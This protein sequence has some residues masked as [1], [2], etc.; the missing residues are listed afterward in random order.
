MTVPK[1]A[2]TPPRTLLV[3]GAAGLLGGRLL[4]LAR[5]GLRMVPACV[6]EPPEGGGPWK[7][8][9][10]GDPASLER[11]F[12]DVQPDACVNL[13]NRSVAE[14][15]RDPGAARRILAEGARQLARLCGSSC[16]LIHFSTDMVYDGEKGEPYSPGDPVCPVSAYGRAKLEAENAVSHHAGDYAIIRSA[17]ILG[18]PAF[19]PNGFLWWM[20]D[21][22][23]RDLP[24]PLF[25]DQLRT[26]VAAD[27]LARLVVALLDRKGP[28]LLLAGGDRRVNRLEMGKW[29]ARAMNRPGA[30]LVP[31]LLAEVKSDAPLQRDLSLDN[32]VLKAFIDYPLA[33]P[34]SE[35]MKAGK[36]WIS[37]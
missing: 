4:R 31:T 24:V 1:P 21:R 12:A 20:A 25:S 37:S 16:R 17:L 9:D 3:L 14:C 34:E 6:S 35:I 19:R 28:P 27:D 11:L 13:V 30:R 2:D 33:D 18:V 22:I 26:P 32:S 5:P 15:E 10:L 8:A 7:R 36:E 23:R 29:M